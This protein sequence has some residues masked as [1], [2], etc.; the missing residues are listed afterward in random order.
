MSCGLVSADPLVG[1]KFNSNNDTCEKK[2]ESRFK[3]F[4]CAISVTQILFFAT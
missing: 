3:Q 1:K 2:R 4:E